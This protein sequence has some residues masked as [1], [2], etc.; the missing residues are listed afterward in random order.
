MEPPR[1]CFFF[2]L[3]IVSVDGINT[4]P[5]AVEIHSARTLTGEKWTDQIC[6]H[7]A[8]PVLSLTPH[9]LAYE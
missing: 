8:N 2:L 7:W 3:A 9:S 5:G 1:Y 4:Q 6:L